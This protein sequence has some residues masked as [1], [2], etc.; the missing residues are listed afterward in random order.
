[1][2]RLNEMCLT[3]IIKQV[4]DPALNSAHPSCNG[5]SKVY[6][7]KNAETQ[8]LEVAYINQLLYLHNISVMA[9][10]LSVCIIV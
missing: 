8:A 1:M 10:D 9:L 4:F 2:L 6:I 3:V 5:N 7:F